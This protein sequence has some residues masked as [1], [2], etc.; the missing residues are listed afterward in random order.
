L[1]QFE[2]GQN[3]TIFT[4]IGTKLRQKLEYRDQIENE[5]MT[6]GII[7]TPVIVTTTSLCH[8]HVARWQLDTWQMFYFKKN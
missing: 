6:P 1:F 2:E 7:L 3:C 5:E 8:Y 4:K